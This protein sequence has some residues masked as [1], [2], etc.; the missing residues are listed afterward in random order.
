MV[1]NLRRSGP[2]GLRVPALGAVLAA[3]T[4]A[5]GLFG[6]LAQA[7]AA[8]VNIYS[9]R[10]EA[11]IRPLLDRFTDE[12]GIDVNLVTDKADKLLAR[13]KAEGANSPADL[14]I[15]VDAAR[16]GQAKEAGVL[17]P[18]DSDV[19]AENIPEHLRDRD[20][21]W[22]GLSKRARVIVYAKDR[23]EAGELDSYEGLADPKWAGRIAVRSS[24][25]V[26][27]Q[28]LVASLIAALGEEKTE[29]WAS[30]LVENFAR[31]PQGGDRDQVKA[32]AAGE[33][34]VAIVNTYYVARM[35]ASTGDQREAA[36]K[37]AVFFPNQGDRGT[38]V[39]VSGAGVV[40][41]AEHEAEA[42][43]LLE[44]LSGGEAQKVYAEGN[45]EY[46]V[47]PGVA[48]DPLVAAWGEFKE[49]RIDLSRLGALNRDAVEL[50]D[51]AGWR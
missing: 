50:M 23:V 14:F 51:R 35:M 33:A 36:D 24:N 22:F 45:Y 49:D 39:N 37:V 28:S 9:A 10:K 15:T 18:I 29:V 31:K 30:G 48:V 27:N 12:T 6:S 40:V 38:H 47:K 34:D 43:R 17:K 44:F 26:Y 20:G 46:P 42:V 7:Q 4:V 13:L 1:M 2:A 16:L 41:G 25:N 5:T 21:M 8:E 11:L 19:L 32:V 3:V